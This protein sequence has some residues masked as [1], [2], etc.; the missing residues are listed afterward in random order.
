ML[1]ANLPASLALRAAQLAV[2][3][4]GRNN[5]LYENLETADQVDM[6]LVAKSQGLQDLV[7]EQRSIVRE[8]IDNLLDLRNLLGQLAMN[9]IQLPATLFDRERE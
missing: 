6:M 5:M 7:P 4:Q 3:G 1:T 9:V 8:Q 2:E